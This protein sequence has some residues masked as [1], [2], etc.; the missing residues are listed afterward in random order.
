MS[1]RGMHGTKKLQDLFTDAKIRGRERSTYPLLV[2]E[3][4]E[5]KVWA[6]FG[7]RLAAD[8]ISLEEEKDSK[9]CQIASKFASKQRPYFERALRVL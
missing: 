2:D 9:R 5:G 7:L 3:G 1:P 6:V 4:G 8:V